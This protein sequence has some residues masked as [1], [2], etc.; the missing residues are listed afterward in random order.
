MITYGT[1]VSSTLGGY[2]VELAE[3]H[4]R[5]NVSTSYHSPSYA[6]PGKKLV[7]AG[8]ELSSARMVKAFWVSEL[9]WHTN[10]L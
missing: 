4:S 5:L 7:R 1:V 3:V 2:L 9:Y 8:F 6:R 10:C